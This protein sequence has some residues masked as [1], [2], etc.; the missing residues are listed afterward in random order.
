MTAKRRPSKRELRAMGHHL[1]DIIQTKATAIQQATGLSP[2]RAVE[3]AI[4]EMAGQ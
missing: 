3:R 1:A 2:E 4:E